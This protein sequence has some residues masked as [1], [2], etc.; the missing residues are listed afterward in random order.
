MCFK[1]DGKDDKFSKL[2]ISL[3]FDHMI[4]YVIYTLRLQ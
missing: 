4:L 3:M 1:L 2:G